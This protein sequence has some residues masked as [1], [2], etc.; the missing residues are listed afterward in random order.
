[1]SKPP[2]IIVSNSP[3]APTGYGQQTKQLV[4]RM[5]ADGYP[6]AVAANYGAPTN[7]EIEGIQVLAEGL[8]KYANDSGPENIADGHLYGR[9]RHHA[10]GCLGTHEPRLS[11]CS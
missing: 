4:K 10:D 5:L 1:M 9:L 3:V 2:V 7:M 11:T 6:A 8:I